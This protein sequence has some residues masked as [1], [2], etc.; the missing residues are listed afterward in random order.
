MKI[1]FESYGI[2][3]LDVQSWSD[4]LGNHE[5]KE[6]FWD[7]LINVRSTRQCQGLNALI[8]GESR[9]GK[10]LCVK[11]GMKCLGCFNFNFE[12]LDACCKCTNCT[13]TQSRGG[14]RNWENWCHFVDAEKEPTSI[15]YFFAPVDCTI[16]DK[17]SLA[18]LV[19]DLE[20]NEGN[21]NVVYLD[22]IHRLTSRNMDEQLLKPIEDFTAIWIASSAYANK[23]DGSRRKPLE[24][25]LQN[26]F[27][28]RLTTQK[29]TE[30]ELAIWLGE[31]CE[32]FGVTVESP[33]T[34]LPKLARRSNRVTGMALQV[35]SKAYQKRDKVL[36]TKLLDDH[37]FDFDEGKQTELSDD[38]V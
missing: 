16:L 34:T 18:Q 27:T 14:N 5:I 38:S 20:E 10:T 2:E 9:T 37:I 33:R 15:E 19:Y 29:P 26:R 36:T 17:Q 4:I 32:Q 13:S 23:E 21:L 11:Y 30:K 1:Q 22:E 7:L 35:L 12:T 6:Y 8:T 31:R 25:M 3:H 28:H 24:K